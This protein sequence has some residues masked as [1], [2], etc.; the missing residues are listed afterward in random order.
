MIKVINLMNRA[1]KK[2][3]VSL[4]Q[5]RWQQLHPNSHTLCVFFLFFLNDHLYK[6][7]SICFFSSS[8]S[9]WYYVDRI[10]CIYKCNIS[11]I[12]VHT[13]TNSLSSWFFFLL[14]FFYYKWTRSAPLYSSFCFHCRVPIYI[15]ILYYIY[16]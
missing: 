12:P 9:C 3:A 16:I 11:R 6:F 1:R 5:I 8:Y 13:H 2:K 15:Y 4:I 10:L 7:F 14:K